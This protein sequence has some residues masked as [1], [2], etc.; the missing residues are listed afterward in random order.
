M[1]VTPQ[2]TVLLADP[3]SRSP[4]QI[5][6]TMKARFK[7]DTTSRVLMIHATWRL[8]GATVASWLAPQH[9]Q[10]VILDILTMP[11]CCWPSARCLTWRSL[12]INP[13]TVQQVSR[14]KA[15]AYQGQRLWRHTGG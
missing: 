5:S 2:G 11:H 3:P 7:L 9:H 4:G 1:E 13:A 12:Y 15:G 8:G 6:L 14:S 10:H